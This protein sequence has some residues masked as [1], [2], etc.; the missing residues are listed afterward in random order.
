MINNEDFYDDMGDNPKHPTVDPSLV[1][2]SSKHQPKSHIEITEQVDQK[3]EGNGETTLYHNNEKI[4][5][6]KH[7]GHKYEYEMAE[8]FEIENNKIFKNQD[9]VQR[10]KQPEQPNSYVEGCDMGWC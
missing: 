5:K 10:K 2:D 1:S 7:H 9:Q 3:E 4:G 8:G 6:F